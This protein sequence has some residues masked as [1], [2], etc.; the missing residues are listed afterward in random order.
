MPATLK[1]CRLRRVTHRASLRRAL[2]VSVGLSTGIAAGAESALPDWDLKKEAEI[3]KNPV[4]SPARRIFEFRHRGKKYYVVSAA[5]CDI[6]R[7]VLSERGE[8]VCYAGGGIASDGSECRDIPI[9]PSH[10]VEVW[11]DPR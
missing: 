4:A 7:E 1:E 6:P 2:L 8:H 9:F 11:R 10:L 3:L 5:C